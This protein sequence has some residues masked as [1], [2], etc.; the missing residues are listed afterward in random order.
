MTTVEPKIRYIDDNSPGSQNGF[1]TCWRL[2]PVWRNPISKA[3]S[4]AA[5]STTNRRTSTAT[6]LSSSRDCPE[7]YTTHPKVFTLFFLV[8]YHFS[9]HHENRQ[10]FKF[11]LP[12]QH[13]RYC[14]CD[15]L[16]GTPRGYDSSIRWKNFSWDPASFGIRVTA[17]FW[18]HV[19]IS[20]QCSSCQWW[21]NITSYHIITH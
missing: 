10:L 8:D 6:P 13:N 20:G 12:F 16:Q 4:S 1:I 17:F 3:I 9:D 14:H 15:T 21:V 11:F 18:L 5:N 7:I 19:S 2:P